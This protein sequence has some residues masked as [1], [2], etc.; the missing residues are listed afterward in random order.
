MS[1]VIRPLE[2]R[3]E[4]MQV[5]HIDQVIAIEQ[6][7]Y[8]HPWTRGNFLDSLQA[9]YQAQMLVDEDEVLAYFVAMKG[10]EEVHLLNITVAPRHQRRGTRLPSFFLRSRSQAPAHSRGLHLIMAKKSSARP[11]RNNRSWFV[12]RQPTKTLSRSETLSSR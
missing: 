9:G 4:A 6:Q 5:E 3:F 12:S 2:A 1:A 11:R 8:S 7:A 10:F